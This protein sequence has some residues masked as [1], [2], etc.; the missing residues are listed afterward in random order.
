MAYQRSDIERVR[1]A[2]NIVE[3]LEGVTTV[4]KAGRTYKAICPFHQEKTPSLSIDVAQGLY[5]C[6]AGE[7]GVVTWE[8]VVPIAK[9]AGN[10]HRL[11]TTG[12]V[13][14]DAPIGSFGEQ[15]LWEVGVS[16]NRISKV[17]YAT[18]GHRWLVRERRRL[19]EFTTEQLRP[20]MRLAHAYPN[21]GRS[22]R[23]PPAPSGVAQGF[24]FGDGTPTPYGS[25]AQSAGKK[26]VEMLRFFPESRLCKSAQGV[27]MAGRLPEPFTR[28][29]SIDEEPGHLYGW[30]AG[31]FAAEGCVSR[32]GQVTLASANRE[33]LEFVR[34]LANRL[35]I[36]TYSIKRQHRTGDGDTLS[37][38]YSVTF[39]G[40]MLTPEFFVLSR[41][42][43]RFE[44]H[45]MTRTGQERR[46]WVVREVRP[47]DRVEEVFCATVDGTHA[48][49][50]EDNI[51][52]GNCF[53]CGA[54]GDVFK[55][56]E[57]TQGLD[58]NEAVEYLA[59][60]AGVTLHRDAEA[61]RRKGEREALVEAVRVAVDFYGERLRS[62]PDAGRARAYL[63]GRG[64]DADV[65]DR[66]QL[67]YS[68]DTWSAL[69]EHLRERKVSEKAMLAAGLAARTSR[70]RIRDWF[71]GRVMF[72]IY[73][74]RGDPVGF[75]ARLLDGT[76]PKYLNSPETRLYQKAR[77]LYGLNWAKGDISRSGY[78]IV[79]EGYTDVIG[80]HLAGLTQAV[81][82]CGT[83]LGE[84]HF[85]LL[86]RFSDRV[87]L[88]FDADEAG[89]GAALRG[90]ELE[91]PVRL[92]LDLRVALMPAGADPA[93]MVQAGEVG[94]LREAITQSQPLLQFRL[95]R[96]LA[97]HNL[98]EPEGRARAIMAATALV[99][100]Q[101]DPLVR[102]E[103]A[104]FI[105]RKV[106]SELEPVLAAAERAAGGRSTARR[107]E[108]TARRSGVER[109]QQG[110]LR[111]LAV[112]DP[113]L[114]GLSIDR[115]LFQGDTHRNAFDL[116]EEAL[117]G[118]PPGKRPELAGLV[119]E[120]DD[121]AGSLIRALL[122]DDEPV[123]DPHALVDRL[124]VAGLDAQIAEL[125]RRLDQAD[126]DEHSTLLAE[127]I[128]L[129]HMKREIE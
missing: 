28:L 120:R 18:S 89:V 80:M 20:G 82:T 57:E 8:G 67:G 125:K 86:R 17:L 106:G 68:P 108:P 3:L 115:E 79:V 39:I 58:F 19:A 23:I 77:L 93:D 69:V 117:Q 52:T 104:R 54:G 7:T 129:E 51:L 16:R 78:S 112:N 41:H 40:S 21:T 121:P 83:A 55:F 114:E 81:A 124:K 34:A 110:L 43:E 85:D 123:E 11:L 76:G 102:R 29:P 99:G 105:A 1:A 42:R 32:D 5:H 63:R 38:V 26:D 113:R 49:T 66:F 91:T 92:D 59:A 37:P 70:G 15:Q 48:F 56:V 100:R 61:A 13:W 103:Y 64:Y 127:R 30:L 31:Y 65:I 14:V 72:P 96:E 9:L 50:I 87:V 126:P 45:T 122:V 53:G 111:A 116:L 98:D 97:R 62:S 94:V 4:K 33:N 35:G 101:A 36:G 74:L 22:G 6:L 109:A 25:V 46:G 75:G 24:V 71:R 84:D 118:V 95:E 2:I 47:T 90:D 73:D 128:R 88:A 10:T 107:A 60:R 44:Q 119:G 27:I 12:G